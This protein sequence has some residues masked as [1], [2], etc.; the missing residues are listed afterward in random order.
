MP[1][2]SIVLP[3]WNRLQYLDAT[4]ASVLAQSFEDWELLIADDGSGPEL[5]AALQELS[6]D[7]RIRVL[8]LA[9]SGNPPA[10]RNAALACASG[11]YVAFI[12]SDDVWMADKL[13]RQ[14]AALRA[15][16]GRRWSYTG[17]T[18]IDG[19]GAVL[20]HPLAQVRARDAGAGTLAALLAGE[21]LVTQS[22]VLVERSFLEEARGYDTAFPI[23]GDYE[24]W[25]RLARGS[26]A[27][28]VADTLVQVRRHRD[29]YSDD[30]AACRDFL[31][32]LT[33]TSRMG[34][35]RP[36]R[37]VLRRRRARAAATLARSCA[38]RLARQ[39]LRRRGTAP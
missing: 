38:R 17:F 16:P 26:A 5:R 33:K 13:E 11:A 30:V 9:H 27:A 37:G 3:T 29:H 1:R 22:S 39:L 21:A 34:V 25:L 18:L 2:V 31:G 32:V 35:P 14:L 6:A 4:I 28:I 24:L 8:W 15:A 10:V 19:S 23:C 12:D 36:L 20:E 7:T